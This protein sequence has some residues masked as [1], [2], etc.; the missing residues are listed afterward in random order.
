VRDIESLTRL[1]WLAKGCGLVSNSRAM[2]RRA[3]A[4]Y[5]RRLGAL[6]DAPP[7]LHVRVGLGVS[8]GRAPGS[9]ADTAHS[10]AIVGARAA[11]VEAVERARVLACALAARGVVIVSGG[12]LG[13][14][15]A[16]HR[17]ALDSHAT[18]GTGTT[19][20]VLGCGLDIIY[21]PQHD[22]LY[23]EI[24]AAGGAVISPFAPDA[25]PRPGHFVRRN[26]VIAGLADAVV[27]IGA[28]ASSGA[29]HTAAAAARYG[30]LV[31]AVPGSAGCERLI[32]QGAAVIERPDDLWDALAGQPR[33]PVAELPQ[34]G[35]PAGRVL[36]VLDPE[37][38][39]ACGDIAVRAG[40]SP[41]EVARAL[42]GLE[43]EGLA[44]AR[45]GQTYV[46]SAL[47]EE[48]LAS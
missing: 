17:G 34:R 16:A 23:D 25:P 36:A 38:A 24:C 18:T 5:P 40:L 39:R 4:G 8:D 7:E 46:R 19:V 22:A 2:L 30:R 3:D 47:A 11:S 1:G 31:A 12:A 45:P 41:R 15:A 14:D 26:A 9:W 42:T 21:P 27:V 48:L 6:S 20:A 37:H 28:G 32:A 33:R 13:V 44:T 10:V 29:L 35:S 43:L